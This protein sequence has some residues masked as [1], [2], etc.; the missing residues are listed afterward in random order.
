MTKEGIKELK[1]GWNVFFCVKNKMNYIWFLKIK[2]GELIGKSS[3]INKDGWGE[4]VE[5]N[6]SLLSAENLLAPQELIEASIERIAKMKFLYKYSN[7][8][9]LL[10]S[11]HIT[12]DCEESPTITTKQ[13]RTPNSGWIGDVLVPDVYLDMWDKKEIVFKQTTLDDY[14]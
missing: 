1:N 5:D 7:L 13:D 9:C 4:I 2:E 11:K 10:I 12:S 8:K 14:I 3:F 6:Y